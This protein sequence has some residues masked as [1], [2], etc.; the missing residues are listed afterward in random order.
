MDSEGVEGNPCRKASGRGYCEGYDEEIGQV[1]F[2]R[3]SD[4]GKTDK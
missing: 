1:E 4:S 2:L 3:M